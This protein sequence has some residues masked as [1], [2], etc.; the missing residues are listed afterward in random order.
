ML[1]DQLQLAIEE[2]KGLQMLLEEERR[3]AT[4]HAEAATK[5]GARVLFNDLPENLAEP[6]AGIEMEQK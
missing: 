6:I 5:V 4:R 3:N 1:N 2:N